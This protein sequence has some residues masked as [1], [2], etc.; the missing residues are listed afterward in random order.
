MPVS[1]EIETGRNRLLITAALFAVG[2]SV[3]AARLVEVGLLA[4]SPA[5]RLAETQNRVTHQPGRADIVDRNGVLLAT[6]LKIASLYADARLIDQPDETAARL[7]TVLPDEDPARLRKRLASGRAFVWLRRHLT[8]RQQFAINRLGIPGLE[9]RTEETR[10]YPA[11]RLTVHVLGHTDIDN[12]GIAGTESRFDK[13]LR[14]D[15]APLRLTL[16]LR[17]QHAMR[18]ELARAMRRFSAIGAAGVVM[19]VTNGEVLSLVSLPDFDPKNANLA[20]EQARFNRATLGVYEMGST[21][22]IFTTAMALDSGKASLRSGYDATKPIRIARFVIRDFHAKRRWLSVP[23]IFMYSSNIGAVKMAL[24]VGIAE[25]R[26]FMDRLGLLRP[27]P[28]ELSE[29]GVPLVPAKW[30]EVNAMTISF[31]HGL[32]VSPVQLTAGVAAIVNGGVLYPSTLRKRPAGEPLVGLRV[33]TERTSEQMRRLM[34]LVVEKGTGRKAAVAG[35]L[36]GGKTGTADKVVGRRY[37]DK[38]LMSS[39]IGAFPMTAPRYVVFAMLDEPTGIKETSNFAT[40][41][42]VAAPVVGAVIARIGPLLGMRPID[43]E[44]PETRRRMAIDI[45]TA[46]PGKRRLASF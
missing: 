45:V 14:R 9:F 38:A 3:V 33:I 39:F 13:A 8:P 22:K 42:W 46:K 7:R 30:R 11:G 44:A 18:T 5:P 15:A 21:F 2:F 26:A 23:E 4:G 40:G 41:G 19:D 28:I 31:G 27:A 34:R 1:P 25:Q 6:S 24:D 32:A 20:D 12:R 35:Y 36:V 43:E 16:D 29:I 37:R 10:L 17:V